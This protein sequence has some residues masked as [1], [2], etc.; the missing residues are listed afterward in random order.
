ME[1][2]KALFPNL[3]IRSHLPQLSH[4]PTPHYS[5]KDKYQWRLAFLGTHLT[6]VDK[7]DIGFGLT[8]LSPKPSDTF[9]TLSTVGGRNILNTL[10][11]SSTYTLFDT[12]NT[13]ANRQSPM[14]FLFS[15]S[16]SHSSP[17]DTDFSPYPPYTTHTL[18]TLLNSLPTDES[19]SF[20]GTVLPSQSSDSPSS[21]GATGNAY[22]YLSSYPTLVLGLPDLR[23]LVQLIS[24]HL[25]VETPF[26]FSNG[27]STVSQGGGGVPVAIDLDAG[28]VKR[29]IDKYVE[30]LTS[31]SGRNTN[32]RKSGDHIAGFDDE[33]RFAGPHELGML[34][35]WGLARV[36]RIESSSL[37]HST[38]TPQ[39]P[40]TP[41]N[42]TFTRGLIPYLAYLNWAKQEHLLSYPLTHF[43][44]LLD[45]RTRISVPVKVVDEFGAEE[46]LWRDEYKEVIPTALKETLITLFALLAKLVAHS[47]KSG[48]TPPG[49][50]PL[51]GP[52]LFGLGALP[53]DLISLS[54]SSASPTV[55][56]PSAIPSSSTSTTP[57]PTS[58]ESTYTAYLRSVHATE[59]C[60]LSFIR[61]QDTPTSLGGGGSGAG[62]IPG[63]LKEWIKDYPRTLSG[64]ARVL[65]IADLLGSGGFRDREQHSLGPRKGAQTIRLLAV[66][67]TVPV[68]DRDLVRSS[69]RWGLPT[70]A[71]VGG[72]GLSSNSLPGNKEWGRVSPPV[73][74]PQGNIISNGGEDEYPSGSRA[75]VFPVCSSVIVSLVI[76]FI[77]LFL[78]LVFLC[79]DIKSFDEVYLINFYVFLPGLQSSYIIVSYIAFYLPSFFPVIPI[80]N[81]IR[82]SLGSIRDIRFPFA[83]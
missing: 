70:Y 77:L 28:R 9:K 49:L 40:A 27:G 59:H 29:L 72:G 13:L 20:V 12:L 18:L 38:T 36:V 71:A 68:Y 46:T 58:F 67:R 26:V 83:S 30:Y 74:V 24:E 21:H 51:F 79:F 42:R 14:S 54:P 81:P 7:T 5:D 37:P 75:W 66:R 39:N 34:L 45:T 78:F 63:R 19:G 31:N 48:A 10:H 8:S 17:S 44:G 35:R 73:Q 82:C 43:S 55:P 32:L 3:T 47:A 64:H 41:H 6:Y 69:A 1:V 57:D 52:L 65:A 16:N 33:A 76:L 23:E 56:P 25:D 60:L 22:G 15:R 11:N 50:S 53:G 61:W 62:G 2:L 80:Q 4:Y